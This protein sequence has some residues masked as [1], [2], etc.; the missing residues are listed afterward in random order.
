MPVVLL[1]FLQLLYLCM[2]YFSENLANKISRALLGV[3]RV[4]ARKR[5]TGDQ[6]SV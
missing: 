6:S 2:G 3:S 1:Y 5:W 4:S